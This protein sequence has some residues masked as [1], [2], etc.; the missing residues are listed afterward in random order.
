MS[1]TCRWCSLTKPGLRMSPCAPT[2]L[3]MASL[4]TGLRQHLWLL[5]ALSTSRV[6]AL[7]TKRSPCRACTCKHCR[8]PKTPLTELR[9]ASSVIPWIA[10]LGKK[11]LAVL[12]LATSA[13]P[14]R[15]FPAAGN[16]IPKKRARL[17][18]DHLEEL[19][20]LH[21]VRLKVREWT[22]IKKARLVYWLHVA[23]TR[24]HRH[25]HTHSYTKIRVPVDRIPCFFVVTNNKYQKRNRVHFRDSFS[26]LYTYTNTSA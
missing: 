13:V 1:R 23:H 22:A 15:M 7:P 3:M 11:F 12:K 4:S 18:C 21:E 2:S 10:L 20:Y 26:L 5:L 25:E 8:H 6:P 24:A 19:M 14:E 17:T 16:I 9:R